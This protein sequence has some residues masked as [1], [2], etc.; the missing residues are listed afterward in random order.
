MLL[1]ELRLEL[2]E[3]LTVLSLPPS[4][5][6]LTPASGTCL[7]P[8][9]R[10]STATL[11]RCPPAPPEYDSV[12]LVFLELGRSLAE[13]ED[14]ERFLLMPDKDCGC[15]LTMV[16]PVGAGDPDSPGGFGSSQVRVCLVLDGL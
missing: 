13:P 12:D 15:P 4:S 14:D 2:L 3:Q 8:G 9:T 16:E 7:S 1:L 6:G 5:G 10:S 11:I